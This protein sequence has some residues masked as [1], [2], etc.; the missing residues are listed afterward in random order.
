MML[1]K[2]SHAHITMFWSVSDRIY[3]SSPIRLAPYVLDV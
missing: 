1:F 2:Y 3:D